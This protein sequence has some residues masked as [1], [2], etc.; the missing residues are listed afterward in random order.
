MS[1]KKR[2]DKIEG[3][4]IHKT[5]QQAIRMTDFPPQP[6]TVEQWV[7]LNDA[8]DKGTGYARVALMR[9]KRLG[10]GYNAWIKRVKK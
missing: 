2:I 7:D 3:A 10:E 1:P 4:L 9:N 6:E 5:G 8:I